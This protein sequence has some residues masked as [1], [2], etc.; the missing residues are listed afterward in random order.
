MSERGLLRASAER[1]RASGTSLRSVH[2]P[3]ERTIAGEQGLLA[4]GHVGEVGVHDPLGVADVGLAAVPQPHRL[5]AHL[6]DEA[7]AVGHEHDRLPPPVELADLVQALAGEGLVAHGQDLVDEEHVGVDVDRDREAQ[8]HVHPRRVRLDGGV[9]ELAQL[10]E[11]DDL[12]EALVHLPPGEAEHDPVDGHV[13]AAADL[14]MEAGAQLDEGGDAAGHAQRAA[15]RLGD[16]GEQLQQRRLAGSVLADDAEGRAARHREGDAVEG[17]EG[18]VGPQV[19]DEAAG[20]ESALQRAELVLVEEAAVHLGD[21][22]GDDGRR[23][24]TSSARVSRRRSKSHAPSAKARSAT[25]AVAASPRQ[26]SK[27]PWNSICW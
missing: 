21:A 14:G 26:W 1:S 15:R 6:L 10:G 19:G 2:I 9:D 20:E 11:I 3:R 13:L 12:V 4:P 16:A 25:T 24:H 8:A 5:V 22:V 23:G 18:L 17:G 7:E 27:W